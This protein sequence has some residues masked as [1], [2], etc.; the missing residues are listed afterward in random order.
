MK[1]EFSSCGMPNS[2]MRINVLL[3]LAGPFVGHHAVMASLP[4]RYFPVPSFGRFDEIL[5]LV[6]KDIRPHPLVG[7]HRHHGL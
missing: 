6:E 1:D 2:A 7:T 4:S 5:Y 3:R